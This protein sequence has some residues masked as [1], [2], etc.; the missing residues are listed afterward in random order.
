LITGA[1]GTGKELI[2]KAIHN[3][4]PRKNGPFIAVHAA[5]LPTSLPGERIVWSRKGIF[6]GGVERRTGR[7]ELADGELCSSTRSENLEPQIQ[8]KLLRVLEERAFERVGGAKT[9]QVD[10]RLVAAPTRI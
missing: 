9:L 5:A 8:V 4:S 2:A 6:Y 7:F 1:T 3:L 10:V